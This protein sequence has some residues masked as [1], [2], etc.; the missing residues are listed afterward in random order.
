VG[1]SRIVQNCVHS[2]IGGLDPDPLLFDERW[3]LGPCCEILCLKRFGND[4]EGTHE[5]QCQSPY[6][7]QIE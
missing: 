3:A 6:T 1:G 2:D 5:G 7:D 4:S